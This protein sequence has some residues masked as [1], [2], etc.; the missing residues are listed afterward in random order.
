[1]HISNHNNNH[2]SSVIIEYPCNM[3]LGNYYLMS[4]FEKPNVAVTTI[5]RM[6]L[7]ELHV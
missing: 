2:Q 6:L 3:I 7:L 5:Q 1:M 4:S